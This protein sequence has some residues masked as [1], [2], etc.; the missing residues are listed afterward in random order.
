LIFN[1]A[2]WE[3]KDYGSVIK[4]S[5]TAV[6]WWRD[7][8]AAT[9][10]AALKDRIYKAWASDTST[11]IGGSDEANNQLYVAALSAGH[12]GDHGAWRHYYTLLGQDT[13]LRVTNTDPADKVADALRMLRH[14]GADKELKQALIRIANDGPCLAVTSVGDE[15]DLDRATHTTIKA[16]LTLVSEMGDLLGQQS[17]G[18]ALGWLIRTYEDPAPLLRLT[19]GTSFDPHARVVEIIVGLAETIPHDVAEFV[20]QK[21]SGA[22]LV[23]YP[24][25]ISMWGRLLRSLPRSAWTADRVERLLQGSLPA[26]DHPLRLGI[27]GVCRYQSSE[28]RKALLKE[29]RAGSLAALISTTT[30]NDL[31]G[32]LLSAVRAQLMEAVDQIRT[33]AANGKVQIGG[34]D[35]A[36]ALGVIVLSHPDHDAAERL[37]ELVA[38]PAV[39]GEK[40]QGVLR[41]MANHAMEFRA[42][43]GDRLLEAADAAAAG[44]NGDAHTAFNVDVTGEAVFLVQ[45]LR[46]TEPELGIAFRKL[47]SGAPAQRMWAAHLA[48]QAPGDGYVSAL[49]ALVSDPDPHVRTQAAGG[50]TKL[51]VSGR[52]GDAVLE[53]LRVAATDPGRAV[54]IAIAAQLRQ[55]PTLASHLEALRRRLAQ[56]PS[57]YVRAQATIDS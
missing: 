11:T 49:L 46:G 20:V 34:L 8:M 53:A 40:K 39:A 2:S 17:A 3:E 24:L 25:R 33:D 51:A 12:A 57:A 1:T 29:L 7:Q 27:L 6:S 43:V 28:A 19:V 56:H 18:R 5:D 41:M 38:D 13:L 23:G 36:H 30:V 31:D 15:L 37:V 47:V 52:G 45:T 10:L 32:E 55:A 14:A 48:A 9:G 4:G 21:L 44:V 16:D 22:E 54:P 42:L 35:P 26:D 50:I